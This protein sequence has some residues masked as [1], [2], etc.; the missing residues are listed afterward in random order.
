MEDL[1]FLIWPRLSPFYPHSSFRFDLWPECDGRG[2]GWYPVLEPTRSLPLRTNSPAPRWRG[3]WAVTRVFRNTIEFFHFQKGLADSPDRETSAKSSQLHLVVA[4]H[5]GDLIRSAQAD[6]P[7]RSEINRPAWPLR[8]A[9][10]WGFLLGHA[11]SLVSLAGCGRAPG[12]ALSSIER[13][14][15]WAGAPKLARL[16]RRSANA[17][18]S[19]GAKLI[20]STS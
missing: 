15:A 1:L 5:A 8:T 11:A 9:T 3:W 2:L 7:G 10:P 19:R 17:T 12:L 14:T 18:N 20:L 4:V 16:S 13:S 6:Q